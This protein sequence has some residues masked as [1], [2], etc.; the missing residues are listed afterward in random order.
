M[1]RRKTYKEVKL[2][3]ESLGFEMISKEYV[4]SK[5]PF[6]IKCRKGH[7]EP[8]CLN[9]L[10]IRKRCPKCS[11]ISRNNAKRVPQ[12]IVKSMVESEGYTLHNIIEGTN[13][14][15][16]RLI[17]Q[18]PNGHDKYN[19]MYQN[20]AKGRR[21]PVCRASSGEKLIYSILKLVGVYFDFEF[22]VTDVDYNRRYRFDFHVGNNIFI[23]YDGIYHYKQVDVFNESLQKAKG[24]DENKDNYVSRVNGAMLRIPFYKSN[25]EIL[26]DIQ[27]FLDNYKV[28]FK[29]I[30][31]LPK[32]ISKLR[33]RRELHN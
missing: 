23:E 31:N 18:C 15:P 2:I 13:C 17:V 1:T 25:D 29:R 26:E 16:K 28:P 12:D 3:V 24:R 33:I 21:C 27:N 4:N 7:V 14:E 22:D 19:V 10:Q 20:F 5:T 32:D 9:N 6:D 8:I 11:I 30:N